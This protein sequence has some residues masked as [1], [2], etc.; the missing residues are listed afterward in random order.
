MK[1][2]TAPKKTSAAPAPIQRPI[3]ERRHFDEAFRQHAVALINGGRPVADVA[4]ELGV[5]P[6]S[7]YEWRRK[8]RRKIDLQAPIP[9]TVEALEDEV[10]RLREALQ[11]SQM[12]EEILKKSMGIFV[13]PPGNP[14]SSSRR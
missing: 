7:L 13:E 10:A 12:R 1:V 8:I 9:T 14:S 11:R 5:S 6:Y 4:R 3:R 2:K